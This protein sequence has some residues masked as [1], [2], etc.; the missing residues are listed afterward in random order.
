MHVRS[1][2]ESADRYVRNSIRAYVEGSQSLSWITGVILKSG[3]P[4]PR[5]HAL[6]AIVA[7]ANPRSAELADWFSDQLTSER[8]S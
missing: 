8:S 6:L 4:L 7:T 3:V 2:E 5:C 1:I